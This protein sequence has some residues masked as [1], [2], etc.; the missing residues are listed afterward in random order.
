MARDPEGTLRRRDFLARTAAAAGGLALASQ[1]PAEQ[2]IAEAAR[3]TAKRKLP[4]PADLPIDTFVVLMMENRS[5]DHYFGWHPDADAKAEGLTY[6]DAEGN[7]IET[8]RLSPDFQGCEHPDP[9]HGWTGGRWQWNGG[10]NDRFVTGNEDRTGSRTSSRSAT[11]SRRTC[12]SSRRPPR[13]T[14]CTTAGSAR[15][16]RRPTRTATTSG[17]RRTAGRSRTSSRSRC[18]ARRRASPGRRSSTWSKATA[19]RSPTTTR[20]CRSRRSTARG[21][22]EDQAR[23]DLLRRRRRRDPA[24]HLL[25][26][27]AVQGRRRRQRPLGGRAS[28]RRHPPRPGVH[29][30]RRQRLHRVTAVRA[31]ARCS[32]TTT[33]GAASST[34]SRRRSSPTTAAT[35]PTSTTTGASRASASPASRSRPSPR[36][37]R[38]ATCR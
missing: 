31:R 35:R 36:A 37:A 28:A 4:S 21:H 12:R 29:V 6:P 33:S 10:K 24:E 3:R 1:L 14:S 19:S 2:L 15:S 20:T 17:A 25:R 23:L 16:W 13:S 30:G 8:Y 9:D 11:T 18:P 26:R 7:P 22:P 34:T 27:P 38:S 5:F 32:S